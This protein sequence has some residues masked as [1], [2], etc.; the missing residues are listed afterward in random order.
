[1]SRPSGRVYTPNVVTVSLGGCF[2]RPSK[3]LGPQL[4]SDLSLPN[5][6]L[7]MFSIISFSTIHRRGEKGLFQN[8]LCEFLSEGFSGCISPE[9]YFRGSD[10]CVYTYSPTDPGTDVKGSL[11]YFRNVVQ[12]RPLV[13]RGILRTVLLET[14]TEY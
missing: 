7:F 10:P 11:W 4:T 12:T 6:C 13:G 14:F 9:T 8:C 5:L 1:M 2:L 3:C